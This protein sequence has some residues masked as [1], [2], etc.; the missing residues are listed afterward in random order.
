MGLAV[1]RAAFFRARSARQLYRQRG[2]TETRQA[3]VRLR[4]MR[5]SESSNRPC[6]LSQSPY[7]PI[8]M[9]EPTTI[10]TRRPAPSIGDIFLPPKTQKRSKSAVFLQPQPVKTDADTDTADNPEQQK[11]TDRGGHNRSLIKTNE[12]QTA[13]TDK[14]I[15]KTILKEPLECRL[16]SF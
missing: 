4:L 15:V 16:T 14:A 7:R 6:F 8:A 12:G 2:Q 3:F 13:K 11:S 5:S 1:L 10:K 9:P